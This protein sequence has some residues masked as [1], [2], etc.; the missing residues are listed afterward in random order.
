MQTFLRFFAGFI[1]VLVA[2]GLLLDR[3]FVVSR[4]I[5][6]NASPAEIHMYVDDLN[7]W[8][9]WSPW[10]QIDQS[11]VTTIGKITSGIGASQTW[12]DN[13]GGGQLS[14]TESSADTGIV[15]DLTFAGDSSVF[16]SAMSYRIDGES[17]IVSWTMRGT[18]EPIIIGNYFAQI[19]DT[20]VGDNFA[21][22]LTNLK[23]VVEGKE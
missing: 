13:G 21:L 9:K 5:S 3:E 2:I 11:V 17:T 4:E 12:T 16:V 19:M 18:M 20:L 10:Q 1:I 8:S 22:G 23:K 15:Y 6:I 7:Q 14:F